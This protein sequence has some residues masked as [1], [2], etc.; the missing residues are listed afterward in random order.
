[1]GCKKDS[2]INSSISYRYAPVAVG[3]S[4]I[5]QVTLLS[6]DL[7]TYDSTYQL[8]ERVESV[9]TDNE[10]R[11]TYRIERYVR[12]TAADEWKIYRVWTSNLNTT[13][14]ER[15]EDNTIYIKLKFPVKLNSRWNGNAKNIYANDFDD[16]KITVIDK[17]L[18]TDS[19]NFDSTLTVRQIDYDYGFEQRKHYEIY[20]AGV[21]MISKDQ[22]DSLQGNPF[23]K[24][25]HYTETLL[26]H[27][28]K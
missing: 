8:L 19:Y 11:P 7:N 15:K 1:M 18:Q 5:Y 20:A 2:D 22:Y 12:N 13:S 6:K 17:P 9:F 16:Y 27:N 26:F 14:L 23:G 4:L 24:V 10:G 21:G 28:K 3:D 25:Y